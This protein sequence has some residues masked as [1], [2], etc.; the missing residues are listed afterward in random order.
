MFEWGRV[1]EG[2]AMAATIKTEMIGVGLGKKKKGE[3][4]KKEF[5]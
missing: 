3:G 5:E 2:N 1:V 4:G